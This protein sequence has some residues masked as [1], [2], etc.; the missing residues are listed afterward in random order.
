[1]VRLLLETGK[2]QSEGREVTSGGRGGEKEG[3]QGR[4]V[5]KISISAKI[6]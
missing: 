4:V 1:M 3:E 5:E 6:W 2:V